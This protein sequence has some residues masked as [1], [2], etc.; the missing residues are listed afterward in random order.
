MTTPATPKISRRPALPLIW[1]VPLVALVIAGWMVA[2]QFRN[3][4]PEISIE[5]ANG[6]GVEPGKTEL[7]HNGVS[8][9]VVRNVTLKPDLTGVVIRLRLTKPA[10]G[11]AR[12][13]SQ[14]WIVHPEV[15]VSGIR[16]LETLV[17]G[18]RLKVRPGQGE[19]ALNFRGLDHPPPIEEPSAGRAFVLRTDKLGGLSPGA[20][21]YYR[22]VKVGAVETTRLS[23]DATAAMIRIRIYTPYIDL[24]RT[25]TQFWNASGIAFKLGLSGA[26]FRSTT[27]PTLLAGGVCFATP[28]GPSL[29]PTALENTEYFLHA[30]PAKEWLQ[31]QPRINIH[32][33]ESTP[34]ATKNPS[35]SALAP[36]VGQEPAP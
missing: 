9:G 24:V 28:D 31:W 35:P 14:F 3:R 15:S 21:V 36:S 10:D 25:N 20:P 12:A 26:E 16:G 7:E 2:R 22:G 6:A 33:I 5:F 11:L 30:D 13:G 34:E 18:V 29:A 23:D 4:G 27:L 8:V 19:P 32:P 1:V 17:T